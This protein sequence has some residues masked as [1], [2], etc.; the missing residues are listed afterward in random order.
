MSKRPDPSFWHGKRVLLTGHTGFKGAWLHLWLNRLGAEV[1]GLALAPDQNPALF[2]LLGNSSSDFTDIRDEDAVSA[3]IQQANPQIVI[4]L[5]AQALVPRSYRDPVDTFNT[6]IMGTIN[7]LEAL[8]E[9]SP[10]IV[11]NVTSDK[12]Y[13]NRETGN[14]FTEIDS[15][16]GD[17]PYSASKAA[18]EIVTNAYA[19]SFL[20]REGILVATARAGNVV[21]GGDFSENRLIPDIWRAV[22]SGQALELRYPD[23]TRPWQHVLEPLEGYLLYCEK[24]AIESGTPRSLNF[25]PDAEGSAPVRKIADIMI[26]AL[27][28]K[29]WRQAEGTF[30]PEKQALALDTSLAQKTLGKVSR[31]GLIETLNWTAAWY[32]AYSNGEDILEVTNTQLDAYLELS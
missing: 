5:A 4:H 22:K 28:G 26:T 20:E 25:G 17:D 10:T 15:L 30:A 1:T 8:R 32:R 31:L 16:G 2:T 9:T 21:G 14:A 11:L 13:Q 3:L 18:S 19:K 23:A 6:N 7:L 29:P 12:V 24:L 27:D